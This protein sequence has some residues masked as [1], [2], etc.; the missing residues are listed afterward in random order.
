L[1]TNYAK[2]QEEQRKPHYT[3]IL[4]DVEKRGRPKR[5]LRRTIEDEMRSTGRW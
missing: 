4:R 2:N 5:T 3:G 1:N